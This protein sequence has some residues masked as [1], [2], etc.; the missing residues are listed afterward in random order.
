MKGSYCLLIKVSKRVDL[1]VGALGRVSF[2]K[3]CYVYV[4]SALN[5]IEKR[6]ERHS[7][8]DKSL[9]WHVDYLLNSSVVSL[10]RVFYKESGDREECWI[11]GMVSSRGE[12]IEGFGCS[13]CSCSSHL[14]KISD[15][16][17]LN[18]FMEELR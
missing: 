18:E 1:L 14:F 11:A 12:G 5:S 4:G 9:H 17:F 16:S 10:L 6:V 7:R 13:D 15:Y 8:E 2:D 3:G